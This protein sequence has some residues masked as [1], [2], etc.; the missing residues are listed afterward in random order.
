MISVLGQRLLNVGHRARRALYFLGESV[1]QLTLRE[2]ATWLSPALLYS[3]P[4]LRQGIQA[5]RKGACS[6]QSRARGLGSAYGPQRVGTRFL[7][8]MSLRRGHALASSAAMARLGSRPLMCGAVLDTYF[9]SLRPPLP[10]SCDQG[11]FSAAR[12]SV[13]W[14]Y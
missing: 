10:P 11:H 1:E 14:C 2:T 8:G 3:C 5:V 4:S 9:S 7:C 6:Q 12:C 13:V